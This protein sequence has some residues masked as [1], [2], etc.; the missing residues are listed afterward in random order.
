MKHLLTLLFLSCSPALAERGIAS[1][2]SIKSNRGTVTASGL[3][4]CDHKM[5]AAHRSLPF[6]TKV[7]V[8]CDKTGKSV[9][10]TITDRGPYIK[11]R[12]IDL[13]QAAAEKLGFRK[14]GL[15]PVRLQVV[16]QNQ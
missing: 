6:G 13:S 8:L 11:G 15:A 10:V 5:T 7:R 12:I 14:K 3:P 2:Y 16:K 1:H 9:L 4:L